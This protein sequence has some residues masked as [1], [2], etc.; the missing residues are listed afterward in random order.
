M[1]YLSLIAIIYVVLINILA[2]TLYGVDKKRSEKKG[3]RRIS[4]TTLLLT[5]FFGGGV[6]SAF[7]MAMFNHKTKKWKFRL[8]VPAFLILHFGI[9][10]LLF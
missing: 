8:W 5:G 9:L 7:G 6:G 1:E 10:I 4:E 3:Q 2:F